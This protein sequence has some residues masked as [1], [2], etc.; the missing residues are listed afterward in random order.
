M[1][2]RLDQIESRYEDLGR[3]LSEPSIVSDQENFRKV[4]KA[5]R[6]LEPTVEKL[7]EY[8]KL[9]SGVDDAKAMLADPDMR[10]MAQAELTELE[11]QL[12]RVE[13]ELTVLLLPKD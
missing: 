12:S 2:A 5:H 6:D 9:R 4:A 11:P 1:F 8:R 13:E 10:E 7:R 3:Q